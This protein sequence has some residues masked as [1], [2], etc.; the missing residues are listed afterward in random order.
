MTSNEPKT[1]VRLKRV[2]GLTTDDVII[3]G[4]GLFTRQGER[5]VSQAEMRDTWGRLA[6]DVTSTPW[7]NDV[8]EMNVS[9]VCDG[10]P[11]TQSILHTPL[12]AY[13][14]LA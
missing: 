10:D 1:L 7:M 13:V 8:P 3:P 4:R 11:A 12:D 2:A 14:V 9:L 6:Y 5:I